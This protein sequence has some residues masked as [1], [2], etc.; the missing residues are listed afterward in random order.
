MPSRRTDRLAV[1]IDADN[2][3]ASVAPALLTEVARYGTATV[4]RAFGDWTTTNLAGW[5]EVLQILAIQK[6]PSRIRAVD[7]SLPIPGHLSATLPSLRIRT[8]RDGSYLASR[9]SIAMRALRLTLSSP[10]MVD[11]A[12]PVS[13]TRRIMRTVDPMVSH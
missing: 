11:Q 10:A 7:C 6:V 13:P 3:Q 2:A 8:R 5:K 12:H 1:L 4:K 9:P